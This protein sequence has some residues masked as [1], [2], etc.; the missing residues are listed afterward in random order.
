MLKMEFQLYNEKY[1]YEDIS[2]NLITIT[3]LIIYSMIISVIMFMKEVPV[4]VVTQE[5][6]KDE[7][8]LTKNMES[9]QIA[10]KKWNEAYI[11]CFVPFTRDAQRQARYH[12]LKKIRD[13]SYNIENNFWE[14]IKNLSDE[15][16]YHNLVNEEELARQEAINAIKK[17]NLFDEKICNDDMSPEHYSYLAYLV[18]S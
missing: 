18:H 1:N 9:V 7:L 5:N 2:Y 12:E 17:A 3:L 8:L 4:E 10:L 15:E 13:N 6:N 16:N 11:K 14:I